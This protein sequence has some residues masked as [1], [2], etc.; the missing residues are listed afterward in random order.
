MMMVGEGD[1]DGDDSGDWSNIDMTKQCSYGLVMM[2]M[3]VVTVCD[4]NDDPVSK[5]E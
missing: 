5:S 4:A 2:V 1:A 3:V